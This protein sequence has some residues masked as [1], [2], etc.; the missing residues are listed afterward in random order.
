MRTGETVLLC[1]LE[2]GDYERAITEPQVLASDPRYCNFPS[3]VF[4]RQ[5]RNAVIVGIAVEDAAAKRAGLRTTVNNVP[6]VWHTDPSTGY[7]TSE[8]T[9]S[10]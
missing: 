7:V 3:V 9:V 5:I 1:V 2:V 10:E 4:R 8:T 6:S